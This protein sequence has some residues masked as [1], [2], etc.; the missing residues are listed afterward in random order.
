VVSRRLVALVGVMVLAA[1]VGASGSPSGARTPAP[2]TGT[3][4][5]LTYNVAGL[6]EGLSGSNPSVNTPL[7]SPLLNDYDLVLVQEDWVDPVPP[8]P[9]FDFFHDDLISQVDHPHLST[10]ATP[11]NGTDPRRPTALVADGLN[12]LS[13]FPFGPITRQMWPNCF[14]GANTSDGGAGDCLSQKGF[15]VARTEFAPGVSVDVYNLHGEAGSTALDEQ[16]SAEDYVTLAAFMQIY[17]AGRAVLVGGDFNL[18]TDRPFDRQVFDTFLAATDLIDVCV[19][20]DCG[21][22]ADQIDKFVYRS[23]GGVDLAPIDHVFER[24]KFQRDD[25]E[26]LS[27][28]DALAVT[29]AW[30]R[31]APGS[32]SGS[33]TRDGAPLA[34]ATVLA[35]TVADTW[36][37]SASATTDAGGRFVLEGVVPGA[38]RLLFRPPAGS[39]L[40]TE[41]F[42]DAT[43]RAAAEVV[44]V[45]PDGAVTGVEANLDDGATVAGTVTGAAGHPVE[46]I[47]VWA[48]G[49]TDVWVGTS[50]TVTA[51]DGTYRLEGVPDASYRI[52][53]RAVPGSGHRSEWFDDSPARRDA[54]VLSLERGDVVDGVDAVLALG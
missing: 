1:G 35:Y 13:R 21:A 52:L 27:D 37:G 46:G 30:S 7:I 28:H 6:P 29:F 32:V 20:V 49:P 8:I 39:G 9:G 38:Y 23:G 53:F 36:S 12:R 48:Y 34:G 47:D 18:H 45:D 50:A 15:S 25:G 19:V 14:G 4:R 24:E 10:P 11:P 31:Q 2:T 43:K 44:T 54:S 26:P 41:W 33:L 51:G 40:A 17:S 22:D 5:A 3:F 16:Y 42:D